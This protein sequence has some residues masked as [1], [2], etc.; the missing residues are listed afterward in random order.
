MSVFEGETAEEL[1][2]P[3]MEK[4]NRERSVNSVYMC[5]CVCVCVK[6]SKRERCRACQDLGLSGREI[7]RASCRE[8]VCYAV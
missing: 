2:G 6:E 1:E 4:K 8:R 3:E 5:V 7:G